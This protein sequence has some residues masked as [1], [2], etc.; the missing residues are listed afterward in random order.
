[1]SFTVDDIMT[2]EE[3]DSAT[4]MQRALAMQRAINSGFAWRGQGSYGR[5]AMAALEAG[6]N[7]LGP[8]GMSDYYGSFVPSRDMVQEGSKGS[9]QRV[10]DAHGEDY[11]KA[12]EA[13]SDD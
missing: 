3:D 10:M 6:D 13:A 12:L 1:M 8:S 2:L 4:E 9:R 7:M 5:A 11:A